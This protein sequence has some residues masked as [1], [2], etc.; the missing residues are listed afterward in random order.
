MKVVL[1]ACVLYP[2]VLREILL[3]VAAEGLFEALWSD[4]ILREWTRATAKLGPAAQMQA[5]TEAALARAAFPRA[6]VREAAA[7]EARLLLP[8]PNDVHVLAVAIAGHADCIVTFNAQDFPRHVLAEDGIERRDPDGLLWQL[9]SFHP[10]QVAAVVARVHAT[11]ES[12][13]GG[14]IPLR[15]LLKRAQLPKLAKALAAEIDSRS[16]AV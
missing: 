15:K 2:T 11:A 3:G 8:D 16:G 13:N 12:M 7:I 10:D 4:R 14:A 6:L 9:W 5:E 1:D